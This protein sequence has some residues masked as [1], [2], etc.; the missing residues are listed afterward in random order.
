MKDIF[1]STKKL[2]EIKQKLYDTVLFNKRF[3]KTL[4]ISKAITKDKED[5]EKKDLKIDF[6]LT[7]FFKD[8]D[9][10]D[11]INKL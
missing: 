5:E 1:D 10:L 4:E 6:D 7:K 11:C 9:M 2:N 8:N 3:Y